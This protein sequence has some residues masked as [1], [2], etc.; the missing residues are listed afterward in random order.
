MRRW[1]DH[2]QEGET[3]C[4][5]GR[6]APRAFTY[7]QWRWSAATL[8]LAAVGLGASAT[9]RWPLTL[10]PVILACLGLLFVWGT[11]GH[12]IYSRLAWEKEFYA[13]TDRRLLVKSGLFQHRITVFDRLSL[14]GMRLRYLAPSLCT[15]SLQRRDGSGS[16]KLICLEHPELLLEK[17]AVAGK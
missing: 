3:L 14:C 11:V 2:L 4:W 16:I 12:L 10:H 7:R 15:V 5:E 6:P 1:R 13:L 17:L 8:L 9:L